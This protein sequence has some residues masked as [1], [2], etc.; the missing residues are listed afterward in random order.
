MLPHLATYSGG[1]L[2]RA[3]EVPMF[4]RVPHSMAF[5]IVSKSPNSIATCDKT[6]RLGRFYNSSLMNQHLPSDTQFTS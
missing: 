1:D 5:D 2:S 3:Y 4:S 6:T